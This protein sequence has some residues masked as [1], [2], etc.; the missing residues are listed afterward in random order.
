MIALLIVTVLVLGVAAF[1]YHGRTSVYA[2]RDRLSV[3]EFVNGRLELLRAEPYT[4]VQPPAQDYRT[5]YLRRRGNGT[6][7][8]PQSTVTREWVTINSAGAGRRRYRM[9]T[10][11]RYVDVD[12]GT[13][14]FDALQFTVAMRYRPGSTDEIEISTYRAP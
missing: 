4:T 3:L 12:G 9:M 5:Y 8:G 1:I 6:W 14:S 2:E 11:V 7:I 10:T 13:A